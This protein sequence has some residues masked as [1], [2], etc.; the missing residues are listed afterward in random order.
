MKIR[1]VRTVFVGADPEWS[2]SHPAVD[3]LNFF[4]LQLGSGILN[5]KINLGKGC[6]EGL[7]GDGKKIIFL[8][9]VR[10]PHCL[11]PPP[12]PTPVLYGLE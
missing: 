10:K 9:H 1:L 6:T 3:H 5:E 4:S 11:S 7:V 8:L 2:H 12:T